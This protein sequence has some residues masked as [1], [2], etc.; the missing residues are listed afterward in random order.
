ML[1]LA[2][3]VM[4]VG[5]AV[6]AGAPGASPA[7]AAAPPPVAASPRPAAA[8]PAGPVVLLGTG[9]VRWDD[10]SADTPTLNGLLATDAVGALD[11]RGVH[12]GPTCPVDGWLAVS[13]GRRA[14]DA[15]RPAGS[16]CREP[17]AQGATAGGPGTVTGWAGY[18]ARAA[19]D[20]RDADPG[21][22]GAARAAGGRRV[23]AVGGGAA[24]AVADRDG[25]VPAVWAGLPAG[26]EGTL[27]PGGDAVDL[28]RQVRAA[29]ASG[30]DLV[31][32]DL[33]TVRDVGAPDG[34]ADGPAS[35]AEQ[36][37][38]LDT[39]L[40]LVG[41]ALPDGATVVLASLADDGRA[42][43][44]QVVAA[45]APRSAGGPALG[46]GL[47]TSRSTREDGLVR[48]T[49]LLPTVLSRLGVG[50]PDPVP[51]APLA[52]DLGGDALDRLQRVG[53]LD[54]ATGLVDRLA[55]P[56]V[57]VMAL[58]EALLLAGTALGARAV[59]VRPVPRHRALTLLRVAA[60]GAALVPAAAYLA[61]LWP[62]WRTPAP[63]AALGFVVVVAALPLTLVALAGPWHRHP[64][65]VAG[66]TG[67]VT[68]VALGVAARTG[69]RLSPIAAIGGQPLV[70]GAAEGSGDPTSALVATGGILAALAVADVLRRRGASPARQAVAVA[71]VGL[72]VTVLDAV[73]WLG[74][75]GRGPWAL[76]P[77]FG[78]LALQVAGVRLPRR[79]SF[80]RLPGVSR[81]E[82]V[83]AT[84]RRRE[85]LLLPG[86]AA[87]GVALF[88][89]LVTQ[90]GGTAVPPVA[91]LVLVPLLVAVGAHVLDADEL[92]RREAAALAAL[93]PARRR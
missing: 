26:P 67:G 83:G 23:A 59:R 10:V 18:R 45:H 29:V 56:F 63:G 14:A 69:W 66:A 2:A 65:Q 57:L 91:L 48:S 62:W 76:V 39:R 19:A 8:R 34:A 51:G 53:D 50:L 30:A 77:A 35:R 72:A 80:L 81:V 3:C 55:V 79:P 93:R 47:L 27:D 88:V 85:P 5:T 42:A 73:P 46:T 92:E 33:G 4:T 78:V 36:L 22:L 7:R 87:L 9:G 32:V 20:G 90:D 17:A 31:A 82:A 49:D 64:L 21:L 70:G 58:L 61:D 68:L 13:A 24:L 1:A 43:H 52:A 12:D 25:R 74:D 89:G 86:L 16:P 71:T 6:A 15:P 41:G 54:R 38:A 44:L 37:T 60:V 84:A 75:D 40:G 11:V 28:S